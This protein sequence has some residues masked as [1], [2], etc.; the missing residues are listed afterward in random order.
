ME[1]FYVCADLE[2]TRGRLLESEKEKSDL[3]S[4][5]QKRLKEIESIKR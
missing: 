2:A 5:A 4:L 3:A 1:M